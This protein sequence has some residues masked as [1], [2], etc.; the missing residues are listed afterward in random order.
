MK[1]ATATKSRAAELDKLNAMLR[2]EISYNEQ[3][4][5]DSIRACH[6]KIDALEK[7]VDELTKCVQYVAS[8]E[9]LF[10]TECT[11]AEE[12]VERCRKALKG[13]GEPC[14]DICSGTHHT[15]D[16]LK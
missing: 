16:C 10:F 3:K 7:K 4:H 9:N 5:L 2:Q 14:C 11:Q 15:D 6:S 13:V 8:L 12:I 1:E